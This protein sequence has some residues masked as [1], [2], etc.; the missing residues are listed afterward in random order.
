MS[1]PQEIELKLDVEPGFLAALKDHPLLKNKRPSQAK[2]EAVYYDTPKGKL[3][4]AGVS[5]RVRREGRTFVQ[6][7]KAE[8]GGGL[9]KRGEWQ[10]PVPA[11]APSKKALRKTPARKLLNGSIK[12]LQPV[13]ETH[14]E[15]SSWN[16]EVDRSKIELAIDEGEVLAGRETLDLAELELE[17]KEGSPE[18]FFSLAKSLGN[19]VPLRL[20]V[21]SKV[22]QGRALRSGTAREV[23]KAEPVHLARDATAGD[24]LRAIVHNCLRHFRMNEPLLLEDRNPAALHQCRVALRRLRSALALFKD[25]IPDERSQAI[26]GS[27][28][29]IAGE[30]GKARNLDVFLTGPAKQEAESQASEIVDAAEFMAKVEARRQKVYGEVIARLDGTEFR[31]LVLEIV[32]WAEI[33]E[34]RDREAAQ[35]SLRAHGR[36]KLKRQHRSIRRTTSLDL[37]SMTEEERHKIRIK[38]KKIRYSCEFFNA[39]SR[40]PKRYE[41]YLNGVTV[42]QERLGD[43]NDAT[44]TR[45]LVQDFVKSDPGVSTGVAFSAGAVVAARTKDAD[46]QIAVAQ[47]ALEKF[48]SAKPFW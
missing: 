42:V 12:K 34:W 44:T 19:D 9:I 46:T 1:L 18:T 22:Q 33:G 38:A 40:R 23:H 47:D 3:A 7:V 14:V 27:L 10:V 4:D 29:E 45:T 43:L 16:L 36:R 15:R 37:A 31:Q 26:R 21:Q 8:S 20:G 25:L 48:V 28:K 5:L 11:R 17:L 39:I 41:R 32:A 6:T 24:A 35:T 30:L 13:V 2:L